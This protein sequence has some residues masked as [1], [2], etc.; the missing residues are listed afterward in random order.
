MGKVAPAALP[1]TGGEETPA[2]DGPA[3][4][5]LFAA[6]AFQDVMFRVVTEPPHRDR[7]SDRFG[8]GRDLPA[9]EAAID[10]RIG[11]NGVRR[12][13]VDLDPRGSLDRVETRQKF[14]A[15]VGFAGCHVD[16][17]H[18]AE[19]I[20][21][22]AVL[23]VAPLSTAVPAI[24]RHRRIRI[25]RA[26]LL[27]LAGLPRVPGL[28]DRFRLRFVIVVRGPDLIDMAHDQTVSRDIRPDQRG[29]VTSKKDH[30]SGTGTEI[31]LTRNRNQGAD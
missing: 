11:I 8:L 15:L 14:L 21:H 18:H 4:L 7:T 31:A 23:L 1:G 27:E 12:H 26:D 29:V 13:R 16:L 10:L 9:L 17:E 28:P 6:R 25:G 30:K 24:D 19:D 20:V 3:G 5:E 22:D 2:L